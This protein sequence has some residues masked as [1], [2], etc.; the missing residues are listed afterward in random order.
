MILKL[1]D[2]ERDQGS[3][4]QN[5]DENIFELLLNLFPN[6]FTFFL[7]KFIV[8]VLGKE[9]G[10][11]GGWETLLDVGTQLIDSFFNSLIKE[12]SHFLNSFFIYYY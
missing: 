1:R 10:S 6:G 2:N 3:K 11:L 5:S 7:F 8:T 12:F 9:G 4:H